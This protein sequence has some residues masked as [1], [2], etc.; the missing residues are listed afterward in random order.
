MG[1]QLNNVAMNVS[2]HVL[3]YRFGFTTVNN[4]AMNVGMHV[5]SYWFGVYIYMYIYI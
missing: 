1:L 4:V 2:V 3:S 5:L